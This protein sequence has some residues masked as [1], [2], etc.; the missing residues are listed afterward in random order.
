MSFPKRQRLGESP[1]G[2]HWYVGLATVPSS[3]KD[4]VAVVEDESSQP[5]NVFDYEEIRVLQSE[6]A[7]QRMTMRL[8][9]LPFGQRSLATILS[10][11]EKAYN[12]RAYALPRILNVVKRKKP[13]KSGK[14]VAIG[15]VSAA[16][17]H[18]LGRGGYG[19]VV[20]LKS[21]GGNAKQ[22]AVKA[23]K[24][25]AGSLAAEF[26]ILAA[27]RTRSSRKIAP[28]AFSFVRLSDG[29]MLAMEPASSS[30]LTLHDLVNNYRLLGRRAAPELVALH[31]VSR[32]VASVDYLHR[33]GNI[34]HCDLKEDNFAL[35]PSSILGGET[36]E[37]SDITLIDFGRAI[38][39]QKIPVKEEVSP[40]KTRLSGCAS[41][42][43]M[44]CLA[45]KAN[46]SWSI[47]ID[48]YG[49]ACTAYFLLFADDM[50][51]VKDAT[52]GRWR[53]RNSLS[54]LLHAELWRNF[55]D[56]L[57]NTDTSFSDNL[58][59]IMLSLTRLLEKIECAL[60][61]KNQELKFMLRHQAN[62]LPPKRVSV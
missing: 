55:F 8:E 34:L 41:R 59:S 19:C 40:F 44:Q 49:V 46:R 24:R 15:N 4:V 38:D 13:I 36:I 27:L 43:E 11:R 30:G 20:I 12:G 6:R 53:P 61:P 42:L 39:L 56:F 51:L 57:V 54:R 25:A 17:Q 31:Y 2:E 9:S 28:F 26:E 10:H 37:A 16:V 14:K 21:G 1:K 32:M 33:F 29:D 7:E 45:M 35:V 50:Q 3:P 23:Q 5:E 58:E 47:D 22:I 62:T 60:Q 52:T 48:Y 18:E